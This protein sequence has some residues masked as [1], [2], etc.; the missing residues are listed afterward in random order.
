M[1]ASS[2]PQGAGWAWELLGADGRVLAAGQAATSAQARRHSTRAWL[3]AGG[4]QR[5][6]LGGTPAGDVTFG[7]VWGR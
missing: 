4:E 3:A 5:C 6:D 2:F 1:I 7:G